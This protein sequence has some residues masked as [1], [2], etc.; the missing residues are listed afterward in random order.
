M[1]HTRF[2]S[3]I[4]VLLLAL[5]VLLG[6]AALTA[7]AMTLTGEG[8][9]ADP[10]RVATAEALSELADRVNN[11]L[12][13]GV[14]VSLEDDITVDGSWT[15]LG[16]NTTFAFKGSFEGNGH[17][18]TV[19]VDNPS[20]SYFGFFG[21]LDGASV[22]NLT[23]NGEVY[24]S[25]PYAYVGG[26]AARARGNVT[27]ENC[28]SNMTVSALGRGSRGIG[29]LVGGYDD[30]IEYRFESI[31]L[32]L[33]DCTNNGLIMVTGATRDTYVGGL[34]G[35][36]P[37]C[38]Q[39]TRCENNGDVYAPGGYAGGLL[40]EIGSTT[41]DC[42]PMITDCRSGGALV[43]AEGKTGRLFGKGREA[44]ADI[45]GSGNNAYSG[46]ENPAETLLAEAQKYASSASV[47]SGA[48]VGDVV[49]LLKPFETADEDIVVYASQGPKD[50]CHGYLTADGENLRLA[51]LNNTGKAVTETATLRLTDANGSVIRKPI[52]VTIYPA[53]AS[54]RTELM[55]A[56]A[57]SYSGTAE[58]WA[59]FDSAVYQKLG[60]GDNLTDVNAYRDRVVNTL[61]QN[62]AFALERAKA[63]IILSALDTDTTQLTPYGS[64]TAYSNPQKLSQMSLGSS[65]YAAPWILLAEE[66]GQVTLTDQNRDAMI[67][68]L[69]QAQGENG[70]FYSVWGSE[71]YDDV[72]TTGT[73][74][75]AMARFYADNRAVQAFCDKAIAGL[76]AAQNESGS[77][78]NINS[79]AMVII[80]LAAMGISPSADARFVKSGG[81]LADAVMLYVNDDGT[82]F[83]APYISG[84]QGEKARAL[85]TEQG[86]RALIVLAQMESCTAFNIYTQKAQGSSRPDV[87]K[88][89]EGY[90]S[91][92]ETDTSTETDESGTTE[93]GHQ[94]GSTEPSET[95]VTLTIRAGETE[96]LSKSVTADENTTVAD[97]IRKALE[98]SGISA[99]GLEKGYIQSMTK[100]GKTLSDSD[101]NGK[102]GWLYTVNGKAPNCGIADYTLSPGDVVLLYYTEDYTKE[103]VVKSWGGGGSSASKDAYTITFESNGGSSTASQNVAQNGTVKEPA[104]PTKGGFVFAG[105]Y[106]DQALQTKYDFTAKVTKSFTLYAAWTETEQNDAAKQLILMIGQREASVFGKTQTSDVPPTIV[107]GRTVLPLRFVAEAFGATVEWNADTRLVTISGQNA[108]TGQA[109]VILITIGSETAMLDGREAAL[110]VSAFIENDRTMLPVRF[111]AEALGADVE[112]I[113]S[114]SKVIM[115]R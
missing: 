102:S 61:A 87:I 36:N 45:S 5:S 28:T 113:E 90:V 96:W 58:E 112:W 2:L 46:G 69:T 17:S 7:S 19:T 115:T 75:A 74:L 80:G 104:I 97:L 44:S 42:R 99:N 111:V 77:F 100:D 8:T 40:G 49:C 11:N 93:G 16:L 95:T 70:L 27:L 71:K 6:S 15:P 92:A 83:T 34:V 103:D 21:C 12:N 31:A 24:C 48:A 63:E 47:P 1:K 79:D 33:N 98:A 22:K 62:N 41:G 110:S 84:A 38:V 23:V 4:T 37:N 89:L 105:W 86:F 26:L 60:L 52:T 72:D 88:R 54:A 73:A 64:E 109:V 108:K 94:G 91:L 56:I 114:E 59:V 20:L 85:A 39:L 82:G 3:K 50:I 106:T 78:G 29:G 13:E 43:G 67:S 55:H 107:N 101:G 51:K 30:G 68:L 76:S 57:R 65:Y 18:V 32:V 9:E 35:S 25:E 66:A 53:A 10:Y 81:S 14:Y